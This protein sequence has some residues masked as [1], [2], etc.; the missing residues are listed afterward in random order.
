M[1]NHKPKMYYF[2]IAMSCLLFPAK[3]IYLV[4]EQEQSSTKDLFTE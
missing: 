2:K 4:T 3:Y 1:G